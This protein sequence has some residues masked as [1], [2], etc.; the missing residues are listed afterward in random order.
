MSDKNGTV[1][2]QQAREAIVAERQ[3]REAACM[4]AI[5]AA[6]SEHNCRLVPVFVAK[7][8]QVSQTVEV[9]AYD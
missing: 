6:L 4:E 3:E 9:L 1:T 8:Q 2:A 5:N 7:G